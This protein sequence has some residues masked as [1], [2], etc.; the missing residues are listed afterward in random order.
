ML[1]NN[2]DITHL[3]ELSKRNYYSYSAHWIKKREKEGLVDLLVKKW[4][5]FVEINR[6]R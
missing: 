2:F 1:R 4:Q 6:K 5:K 3:N